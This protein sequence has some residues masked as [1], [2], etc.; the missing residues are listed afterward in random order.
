[1]CDL[2][3]L[4]ALLNR[5]D[6]AINLVMQQT[7]TISKPDDFLCSSTGMFVLGGVCMQLIFVG[8]TV[9]V[10][11]GKFPNYLCKYPAVPWKEI[12]GLRDII[13]HEYHHVDAE[14]IFAVLKNDLPHLL[15]IVHVMQENVLSELNR[16][17]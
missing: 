5:I 6:E 13:A 16:S 4:E 8:E 12:M 14:E 1:M 10:I 11:D 7:A 17:Q 9:K 2:Y 3:R 15:E